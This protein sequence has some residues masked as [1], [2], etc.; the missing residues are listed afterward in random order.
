MTGGYE[1]KKKHN[2]TQLYAVS[3]QFAKNRKRIEQQE[4]MW[5]NKGKNKTKKLYKNLNVKP[6]TKRAMHT[7][8][9]KKKNMRDGHLSWEQTEY[10]HRP[11]L[12]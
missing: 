10:L 5:K 6:K 9:C 7:K 12:I 1:K 2:D 3:I 4:T 8:I 11:L